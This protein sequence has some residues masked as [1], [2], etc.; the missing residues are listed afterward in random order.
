MAIHFS[1]YTAARQDVRPAVGLSG[2]RPSSW[3]EAHLAAAERPSSHVFTAPGGGAAGSELSV[4]LWV[5]ATKAAG[6]QGLRVHDLRHTG[7]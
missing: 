5:P 1:T 7:D 4:A 6:L 2:C 3:L